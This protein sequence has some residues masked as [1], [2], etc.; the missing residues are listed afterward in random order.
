MNSWRG[1]L[2]LGVI[3][4]G[5]AIASG[6]RPL[7]V[8]GLGFLLAWSATWLWT[9]LAERPVSLSVGLRPESA[10]EGDRVTLVA[11]VSRV[12]RVLFGSIAV[13]LT[14]GRLGER[15]LRLRGHGHVLTGELELGPLPRGMYVIDEAKV[16]VGDLLGLASV[17]PPVA[18]D[19]NSG[20]G[21]LT[22]IAICLSLGS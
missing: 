15:S 12:S 14:V 16:V 18:F 4:L 17:T 20:M 2:G 13:E 7:G 5:A 6:S 19:S 22:T 9:W 11:E 8:V 3:A 10:D 21:L 1:G